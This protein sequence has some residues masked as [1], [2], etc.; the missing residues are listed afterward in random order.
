MS[1]GC[2]RYKVTDDDLIAF[3]ADRTKAPKEARDVADEWLAAVEISPD[4]VPHT[5]RTVGDR[6][7][8]TSVFPEADLVISYR[9][10]HYPVCAVGIIDVKSM[11]EANVQ[12][13]SD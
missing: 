13:R 12:E 6:E 1:G 11:S 4:L 8:R 7:E 2:D 3:W 5:K 9:V 10:A